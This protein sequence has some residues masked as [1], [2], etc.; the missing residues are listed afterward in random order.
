MYLGPE[1]DSH[2]YIYIYILTLG[3]CIHC[4]GIPRPVGKDTVQVNTHTHPLQWFQ[5]KLALGLGALGFFF[6]GCSGFPLLGLA[7]EALLASGETADSDGSDFG[8]GGRA[9]REVCEDMVAGLSSI[10]ANSAANCGDTPIDIDIS[11]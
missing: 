10:V 2:I 9:T 8:G 7:V 4:T 3:L 11:S 1:G 5:N 6:G